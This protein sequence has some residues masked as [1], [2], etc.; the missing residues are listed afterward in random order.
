M[1]YFNIKLG[2]MKFG[3]D[4]RNFTL[5]KENNSIS[6]SLVSIKGVSQIVADE[7]YRIANL[8]EYDGFLDILDEIKSDSKIKSDQ[9]NSLIE[10]GYFSEY[11]CINY[12]KKAVELYTKYFKTKVIK[13]DGIN[14]TIIEKF[15]K[16]STEKQFREIDTIGLINFFLDM[17]DN[18]ITTIEKIIVEHKIYGE[19]NISDEEY[20]P[21]YCIALDIDTTYSP[22][23]LFYNIYS[24]RTQTLK[25]NKK[26]WS[27]EKFDL[28]DIVCLS[29]TQE[30]PRKFLNKQTGK[31]EA[32]GE[33]EWWI[34]D[35][36]RVDIA[37]E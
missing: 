28:Y 29:K 15:A 5:N 8:R 7:I 22:K 16:K 3:E 33:Y 31:W 30:K 26:M 25:I 37:N 34:N 23:I 11:G 21:R 2:E 27:K 18:E 19:S 13:K 14:D 4:N 17:E 9:L 10:I 35:Y 12:L 20:D 6:Q 24:G 1:K 32:T 36:W